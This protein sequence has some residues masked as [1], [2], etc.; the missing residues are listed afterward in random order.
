MSRL[1]IIRPIHPLPGRQKEALDWLRETEGVRKE[2]GQIEQLVL[3]SV[4]DNND[5]QLVQVWIDRVAYQHWRETPARSRLA[6]ERQ[7]YLTHDPAR[8]YEVT[9]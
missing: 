9:S 5:Y 7:L 6:R 8:L 4:V 2:A 3:R 1:L